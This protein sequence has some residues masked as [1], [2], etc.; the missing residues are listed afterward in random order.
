M[1]I[2]KQG[3]DGISGMSSLLAA[4]TFCLSII[5]FALYVDGIGTIDLLESFTIIQE[6]SHFI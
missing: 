6:G 4:F 5:V 3:N 1:A 2:R